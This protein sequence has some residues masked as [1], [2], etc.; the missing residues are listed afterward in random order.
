MSLSTHHQRLN[1]S[2]HP[3]HSLHAYRPCPAPWR[4]GVTMVLALAFGLAVWMGPFGLGAHDM[5]AVDLR[6]KPPASAAHRS[7]PETQFI[8]AEYGV[9]WAPTKMSRREHASLALSQ[10]IRSHRSSQ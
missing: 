10:W 7:E 5:A 6:A 2:E 8:R 9:R 4:L 3:P 1:E